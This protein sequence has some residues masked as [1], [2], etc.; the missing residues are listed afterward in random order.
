LG[1]SLRA[2]E[3]SKA[4]VEVSAV[5]RE[6]TGINVGDMVKAINGQDVTKFKLQDI[7]VILKTVEMPIDITF[8]KAK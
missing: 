2:S 5:K 4:S 1:V 7:F 6:R 3:T 8:I